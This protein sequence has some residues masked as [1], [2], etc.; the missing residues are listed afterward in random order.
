M[1]TMIQETDKTKQEIST[2]LIINLLFLGVHSIMI[3]RSCLLRKE[4]YVS[5]SISVSIT[6]VQA[7]IYALENNLAALRPITTKIIESLG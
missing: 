7:N 3:N 5:C 2:P 6:H 1:K 4:S